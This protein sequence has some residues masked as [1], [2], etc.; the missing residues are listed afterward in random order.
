[1]GQVGPN[2]SIKRGQFRIANSPGASWLRD[3]QPRAGAYAQGAREGAP[4]AVQVA[5]RFHL[6]H[7]AVEV[8]NTFAKI[9]LPNWSIKI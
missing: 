2:E 5:D 1:M 6:L 4:E 9:R 7:N 8:F 3:Y